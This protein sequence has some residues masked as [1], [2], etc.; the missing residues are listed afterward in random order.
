MFVVGMEDFGYLLEIFETLFLRI[1]C[2]SANSLFSRFEFVVLFLG[3]GF[4]PILSRFACSK[5]LCT[6]ESMKNQ[7]WFVFYRYLGF[8]LH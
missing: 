5:I 2:K 4:I 6:I 3:V 1:F 7:P 8:L